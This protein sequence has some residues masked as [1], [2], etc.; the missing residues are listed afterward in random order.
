MLS[1]FLADFETHLYK[2]VADSVEYCLYRNWGITEFSHVIRKLQVYDIDRSARL[3][4]W[5][6]R[7]GVAYNS[8]MT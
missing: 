3:D 8:R 1:F 2:I 5:V 4:S 6:A 7:H